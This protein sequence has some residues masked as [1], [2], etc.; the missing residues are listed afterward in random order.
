MYV[1]AKL[2]VIDLSSLAPVRKERKPSVKQLELMRREAAY[3]TAISKLQSGQALSFEPS[4]GEKTPAIRASL[5]RVID[6]HERR[7][8]LHLAV[9]ANVVYVAGQPI[10]GARKPRSKKPRPAEPSGSAE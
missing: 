5:Q 10:P 3:S 4:E 9:I 6:R 1:M 8:E 7:A 2:K